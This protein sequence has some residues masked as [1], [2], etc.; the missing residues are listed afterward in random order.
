MYLRDGHLTYVS[1]E[2]TNRDDFFLLHFIVRDAADL[3]SYR[4]EY[5]YANADFDFQRFGIT[6]SDGACV[7]DRP[8]P[9]YDIIA[10]RTGQYTEAGQIWEEEY[11]LPSP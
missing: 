1:P 3:P 6:L 9:E 2:C 5:G 7:M 4:R 11:R 8:L 10:I